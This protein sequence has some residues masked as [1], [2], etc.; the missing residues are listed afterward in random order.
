MIKNSQRCYKDAWTVLRIITFMLIIFGGTNLAFAQNPVQIKFDKAMV[1]YEWEDYDKAMVVFDELLTQYPT[2]D[3]VDD[4]QYMLGQCYVRTERYD[5]AIFAFY[6]TAYTY[7]WSNRADDA[8][9][10]LASVLYREGYLPQALDSY[11]QLVKKYPQSK[12]AAYAQTCIGWLYGGMNNSQRAKAELEKVAVNYPNS[13]YVNTAQESI[14]F[15]TDSSSVVERPTN[16]LDE[17]LPSITSNLNKLPIL[18][19]E[20][21]TVSGGSFEAPVWVKFYP[22]GT[23]D[24]DGY[25]VLFEMDMDGDGNYEVQEKTLSGGSYEFTIPGK[26]TTTVRVT[27]NKGGITIKSE[28]FTINDP[29]IEYTEQPKVYKPVEKRKP[30]N[31]ELDKK[32]DSI[33]EEYKVQEEKPTKVITEPEIVYK[34]LDYKE[35]GLVA[36]Y[37]FNGDT[38][39]HSGNGNHGTNSGATF[40]S[41][42]SGK[43]LEFDGNDCVKVLSNVYSDD[44]SLGL[45]IKPSVINNGWRGFAGSQGACGPNCRPFDLW[46]MPNNNGLHWWISNSNNSQVHVGAID[47][48][49]TEADL[50][51]HVVFVKDG[52]KLTM[53]KNGNAIDLPSSPFTDIYKPNIFIIGAIDNYFKGIIDEVKIYDYALNADEIKVSSGNQTTTSSGDWGVMVDLNV[54]DKEN[55]I[56]NGSFEEGSPVGSFKWFSKGDGIPGWSITRATVDLVGNYFRSAD[57]KNSLDLNGTSYGEIQQKFSTK[58]GKQYKLSFYL[59]GNPGGGPT[60]KKLLVSVGNKSEEYQ[61]DITGKNVKE[62]GWEYHELIFTSKGK[63]TIL[64]FESNHKSGPSDA[65]PVIDNI[66]VIEIEKSTEKPNQTKQNIYIEPTNVPLTSARMYKPDSLVKR[67]RWATAVD[68]SKDKTF[69]GK[70]TKKMEPGIDWTNGMFVHPGSSGPTEMIYY[71]DGSDVILSGYVSV[72]DCIDYCGNIGDC[73]FIIK[74]DGIELWNS[75]TIRHHDAPRAFKVSLKGVK[76]LFLITNNGGDD[77]SEDWAMW[78]DLEVKEQADKDR[79]KLVK[80]YITIIDLEDNNNVLHPVA[81]AYVYAYEYRNWDKA[82]FGLSELLT[83]GLH[84]TGG[85]QRTYLKFD[86]PNINPETLEKAVLKL[87]HHSTIGKNIHSIGVHN[88]LENW[89]EGIGTFHLGQSEDIDTTGAVTWEV[90]PAFNDS[91]IVQFKPKKK[92]KKSKFIEIDITPLVKDWISGTPNNGILLK[93]EGYLSGRLPTSIYK[94]YSKEYKDQSKHPLLILE[95]QDSG[96]KFN[97]KYTS[98]QTRGRMYQNITLDFEL[99]NTNGWTKTGTAFNH[100]PTYG[101]NTGKRRGQPSKH[102]GNYWIGTY[103]KYQGQTSE[104]PGSIQGD[105]PKGTLTSNAFTIP[106]GSLSFLIGGGSGSQ[107]RVELLVAGDS[108]LQA[109]GRNAETM[110]RVEWN[111]NPWAG[112]QGQIK[113]VDNASGAWGHINADD[114]IINDSNFP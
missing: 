104:T 70:T 67:G 38:K 82:N 19:F 30:E 110:H 17:N 56:V 63:S 35:D 58:K 9:M 112:Q 45:W 97:P 92:K 64:T 84:A 25:I 28:S 75:G 78:M 62:M 10:A 39:D 54:S 103:E 114:F 20:I 11:E 1:N 74:G 33:I 99:G 69:N 77:I 36:Y 61:F 93:P 53:Y 76:T 72:T 13:S 22:S 41:G 49:F 34:E 85:E 66:K 55:L 37:P 107:T 90:Q 12:H 111:L 31:V 26:Y 15:I 6:T 68:I 24:P 108:V 95:V 86:I 29:N 100:Q 83:V 8:L 87:Y 42:V 96:I 27:D 59:A 106:S 60:I 21:S 5:D 44:M 32:L 73:G 18:N 80:D 47:N 71:H 101:D 102:I 4:M 89:E 46:M 7:S 23:Y 50:W 14:T 79:Q 52:K 65:G 2:S 113:I 51:Y 43:A 16:S 105:G 57:G 81:D 40:V 3:L 88:V 98:N 94:F 109:S 91:S 48:F